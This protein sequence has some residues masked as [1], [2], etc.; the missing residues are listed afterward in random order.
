M[1]ITIH[2]NNNSDYYEQFAHTVETQLKELELLIN[3]G[4]E[5]SADDLHSILRQIKKMHNSLSKK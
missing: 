5:L 2:T 4:P 1:P 3:L